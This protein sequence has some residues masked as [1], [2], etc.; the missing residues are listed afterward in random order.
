MKNNLIVFLNEN[1]IKRYLGIS[2]DLK[3]V[4]RKADLPLKIDK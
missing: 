1:L 3:I 4:V 2:I